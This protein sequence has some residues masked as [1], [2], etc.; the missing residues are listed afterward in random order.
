MKNDDNGGY[1]EEFIASASLDHPIIGKLSGYLE[2]FSNFT[3][4][5]HAGWVG[6]VDT[7]LEYLVTKNV[8][9]DCDCYF[10]VRP[11]AADYNPFCGIT[12]RF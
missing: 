11:A 12:V 8:Q 9:L 6:T 1:H 10:G 4:E 3:T 7:G 5:R 2:F